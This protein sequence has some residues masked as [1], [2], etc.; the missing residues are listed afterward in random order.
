MTAS[1]KEIERAALAWLTQ[2]N[3]PDFEAWDAWDSWMASDPRHAESY[4]ILAEGEAEAIEALRLAAARP[5]LGGQD[6]KR[7]DRRSALPLRGAIAA[8]IAIIAL[9]GAGVY[10]TMR[11]QPWTVESRPGE[12]LTLALADGSMVHLA[13]GTRLVLDRRNPREAILEDGRALFEVVHDGRR[14]FRVEVGNT[15]LTDLG[16]IFDVT[17]LSNGARVAVAEGI[18]QVDRGG[19]SVTL[20]AGDGVLSGPGG[21]ERRSVA[22]DDVAAWRT[23]RLSY[24]GETLGVVAEDLARALN[25][26]IEVSP[27]LLDRRFSGSL[28]TVPGVEDMHRRLSRM[29]GVTVVEDGNG[30]RLEP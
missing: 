6:I 4:W 20:H 9:G 11:P 3:D 26:P 30:W 18:V 7:A 1:I 12:Q 25:R 15:S 5:D 24:T 17:R 23:G 10:W 29:L 13:G 21:L 27:A 8:A 14:P 22:P 19:G 28:S 16:T 2:V